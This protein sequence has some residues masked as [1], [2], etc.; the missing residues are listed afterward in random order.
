[1]LCGTATVC[2]LELEKVL[3]RQA[4][5]LTGVHPRFCGLRFTAKETNQNHGL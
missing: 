5:D 2:C 1:V 3:V 4:K